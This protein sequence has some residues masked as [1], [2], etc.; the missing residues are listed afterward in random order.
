VAAP[1]FFHDASTE[2]AFAFLVPTAASRDTEEQLI[3]KLMNRV[4][5]S[6]PLAERRMYLLQP[7]RFVTETSFLQAVAASQPAAPARTADLDRSSGPSTLPGRATTTG[8]ERGSELSEEGPTLEEVIEALEE[9]RAAG[10]LDESVAALRPILD[11]SF[12]A[13]VTERIEGGG[14]GSEG[15][16][17]LRTELLA[18]TDR[19]DAAAEMEVRR[20][21]DALRTVLGSPD[22]VAAVAGI[23]DGLSPLFAYVV[24]ANM[25]AAH[26]RGDVRTVQLL[27]DVRDAAVAAAEAGLS[28]PERLASKLARAASDEE[29]EELLAEAGSLADSGYAEDLREAAEGARSAGAVDVATRLEAAAAVLERRLSVAV[30]S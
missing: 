24:S 12:F 19:V 13:A 15:L 5:D 4:L 10:H 8:P 17:V 18:A 11:Y 9:S 26:E 22:P 28:A 1:V 3:G 21:V 23:A 25:E 29:R 7:K 2:S 27:A 14:P 20:A 16:L 6:L 30:A